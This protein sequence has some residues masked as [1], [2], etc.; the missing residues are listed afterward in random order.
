M[1]NSSYSSM[2]PPSGR[3]YYSQPPNQQ[4]GLPIAGGALCI[5][6][7]VIGIIFAIIFFVGVQC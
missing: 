6:G 5:V 2:P 3:V 7:G 4:T 1:N